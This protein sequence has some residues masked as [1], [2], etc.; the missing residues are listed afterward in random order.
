MSTIAERTTL[1]PKVALSPWPYYPYGNLCAD[2]VGLVLGVRELLSTQGGKG[3][4]G[5]G[6]V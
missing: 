2:R 1:T 5:S 4:I 3:C 6:G